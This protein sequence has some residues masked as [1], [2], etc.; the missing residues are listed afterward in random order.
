MKNLYARLCTYAHSRAG[1]NNAD[2][3]QSN[4]PVYVRNALKVVEAEFRETLALCYLLLRLGWP[5][6]SPGPGGPALL[7]APGDEWADYVPVLRNWLCT[8]QT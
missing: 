4:G 3:W 5:S 7:T 8:G 1:H 2:F 6:Y